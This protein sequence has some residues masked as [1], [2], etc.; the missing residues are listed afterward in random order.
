MKTVSCIENA[1][2]NNSIV[3]KHKSDVQPIL[4]NHQNMNVCRR[5]NMHH[6][7]LSMSRLYSKIRAY[8]IVKE[9]KSALIEVELIEQGKIK[10]KSLEQIFK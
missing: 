10:P 8:F 9:I 7:I 3:I 5:D 4:P 1:L 6:H 2:S